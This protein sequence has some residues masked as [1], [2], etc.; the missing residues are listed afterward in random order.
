VITVAEPTFRLRVTYGKTGRLRF[1]SHLEVAHACERAV[2]RTGL[3]YA[4]TQG[5]NPRMRI[6]TGPALPVGSAGLAESFDL[7]LTRL[8]PPAEAL[9][10]LRAATPEGLAP[11]EARYVSDK[12]PSLTA[13]MTL[14]QYEVVVEDPGM[15]PGRLAEAIADVIGSGS[16]TI[17]HKGALKVF[18][19][20]VC[21][22]EGA[23]VSEEPGRGTV[24]MTVHMGA[25]G[26][27]RPEALV[28]EALRRM[29]AASASVTVTRV[30][31]RP[32][33]GT[34]ART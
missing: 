1:L 28:R 6:A 19:L 33:E 18:D 17:E 9:E 15:G 12:E 21:L 23:Q 16:L 31:L 11:A 5:F 13:A 7:W 3:E 26:T 14:G 34:A 25:W 2:R 32:E 20:A 24:R 22:P 8:V 10:M 27:L 29:D 4:V 30:A